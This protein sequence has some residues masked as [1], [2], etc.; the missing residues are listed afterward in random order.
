MT[1]YIYARI[2]DITVNEDYEEFLFLFA[3][4]TINEQIIINNQMKKKVTAV[5]SEVYESPVSE[6]PLELINLPDRDESY[7]ISKR[8]FDKLKIM[9]HKNLIDFLLYQPKTPPR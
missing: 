1:G 8:E 2:K 6:A 4:L 3:G 5:V 7:Y 9:A